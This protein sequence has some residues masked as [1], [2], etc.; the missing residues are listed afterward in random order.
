MRIPFLGDM[1]KGKG[2]Q[3]KQLS[4]AETPDL[5]TTVGQSLTQKTEECTATKCL[6]VLVGPQSQ[7][8]A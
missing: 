3:E 5:R 6:C 7:L 4:E 1:W 2:D 8:K